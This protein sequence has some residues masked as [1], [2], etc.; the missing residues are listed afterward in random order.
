MECEHLDGPVV[1]IA[2]GS[3]FSAALTQRGSIYYRGLLGGVNL[4]EGRGGEEGEREGGRWRCLATGEHGERGGRAG[5][6]LEVKAGLHY[7]AALEQDG[8]IS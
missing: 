1:S 3:T 7:L 2:T 8:G 5:D 6:V 4:E